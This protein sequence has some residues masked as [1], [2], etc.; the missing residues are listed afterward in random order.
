MKKPIMAIV[1]SA[2]VFLAVVSWWRVR[3]RAAEPDASD[4]VAAQGGGMAGEPANRPSSATSASVAREEDDAARETSSDDA[5]QETSSDD[6]ESKPEPEPQTEEEKREAEEEKMVD[7]FD[8]LTDAWTDESQKSVTLK[9][10]D[11]FV[12]AFQRIPKERQDE[13]IHRALNLIPDENAMLLVGVLMDK[14]IDKDVV[15]TVFNDILNRDEN[16]KMVVVR[17][18]FKDKTHPCWG[19]AAWILDATGE[20]P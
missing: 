4:A 8:E 12:A 2:A 5:A 1:L 13:C 7:A 10:V 9:D 14:S 18:I 15:E 16:V 6:D 17:Q 20:T 19:D 11:A 3:P